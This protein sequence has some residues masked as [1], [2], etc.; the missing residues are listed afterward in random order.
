M[1]EKSLNV[2]SVSSESPPTCI[3]VVAGEILA[4]TERGGGRL[5]TRGAHNR[6]IKALSMRGRAGLVSTCE[7]PFR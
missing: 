1:P 4:V 7:T 2:E 6:S 5:T 3:L